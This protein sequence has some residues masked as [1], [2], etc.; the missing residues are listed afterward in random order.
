MNSSRI[1]LVLGALFLVIL[2]VLLFAR[3]QAPDTGLKLG[4]ILPLTGDF[5]PLAEEMHRGIE[6]AVDEG[7]STGLKIEYT[8]EDD[9][10]EQSR[11]V[12][13]AQ[14]SIQTNG[15]D[16]VIV[17]IAPQVKAA[18]PTFQAAKR[19]LLSVWDS[20]DE[21]KQEG[22]YVF[23]TGFSTEG[24]GEVMAK[25]AY[26]GLRL[27]HV[28]V[29]SNVNDW[30]SVI[31]AAFIGKYTSMGG[32]ITDHEETSQTQR[33][34]RSDITKVMAKN[35]DA[36]YFPLIVPH[37][38]PFTLQ[39]RQLGYKGV[40]LSADAL[41]QNDI[42]VAGKTI[43]GLYATSLFARNTSNLVTAYQQKYGTIPAMLAF[44][45]M[46]YDGA[47]TIIEGYKISLAKHLPL[48]DALTQVKTEGAIDT[49]DMKGGRF[50]DRI[51]KLYSIKN[52]QQ[53]EVR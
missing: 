47:K 40:L 15:V 7:R 36:L 24:A 5:A 35:P 28:A 33:D 25:H 38:G 16:A 50:A 31:A 3:N 30:S 29:I 51:E 52:A 8:S 49:I 13:A 27:K 10:H 41:N 26:S 34:W 11:T 19:L 12:S 14:K 44:V 20:N 39:A 2:G 4:S 42:Q 32:T 9:A 18:G 43:E 48:R 6:I 17:A 53:I 1:L 21:I 46:G 22:D 23:S 45:A 37:V